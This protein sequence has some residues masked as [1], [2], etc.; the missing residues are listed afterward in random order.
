MKITLMDLSF[1]IWI[2]KD[3]SKHLEYPI[4]IPQNYSNFQVFFYD[5]SSETEKFFR[6]LNLKRMNYE[7][8]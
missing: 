5:R 3:Y 2:I 1:K 6:C 8:A 7:L 4:E